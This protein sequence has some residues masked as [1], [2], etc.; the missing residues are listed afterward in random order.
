MQISYHPAVGREVVK[1]VQYYDARSLGLGRAFKDEVQR[2]AQKVQEAPL[3]FTPGA[4]ETRRCPLE[5]FPH[6]LVYRVE[7]ETV[8]VYAVAHPKRK[9]NYWAE[10]L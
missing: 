6:R 2:A 4:H 9:P 3:R 10:R 1:E 5:R 7:N 8:R